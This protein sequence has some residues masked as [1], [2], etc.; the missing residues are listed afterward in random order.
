M[1]MKEY[2]IQA[3][4]SCQYARLCTY[5]WEQSP[6]LAWKER[7]LILMCPGGGY[8][9]TSDREA[10]PIAMHFLEQ[11]YHVA[12]LRYSVEP[13]VYPTALLEAAAS[14]KLIWEHSREWHVDTSRI[15]LQGCSAGG[16]LAASLGVFWKEAWLAE[17]TGVSSEQLKPAGMILCYPVIT[18]GAFAHR[19][20]FEAL[21]KGEYTEEL[22]ERNSLEKQ[23]TKDTPPTFLWHTYTDD[24][25]PV[26]NSLLLIQ[27]MK[28]YEIPVEFH[29][30]PVGGHGLATCDEAA[31]N[32][33]HYGIQ[34]ECQ[35]WLPL[36][37]TWLKNLTKK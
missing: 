28:T 26:E 16:H 11:G 4:G 30:Y 13:A 22:L 18:S 7:P 34:K 35:S 8:T 12:I 17:K 9:M 6:E 21:L 5:I 24:T 25:V 33:D 1:I 23:V 3:E 36:V 20:S 37:K 2:P 27:A 32:E 19:G 14:M 15:I 31:V 29:M 10:D